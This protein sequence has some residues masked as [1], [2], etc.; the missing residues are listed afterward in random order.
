MINPDEKL[1]KELERITA[2][3]RDL[4]GRIDE[5]VEIKTRIGKDGEVSATAA[6]GEY[7]FEIFFGGDSYLTYKNGI[8]GTVKPETVRW[9][10]KPSDW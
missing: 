4:S 9:G 8:R 3:V 7:S 5:K 2:E 1:V 6:V 10:Q